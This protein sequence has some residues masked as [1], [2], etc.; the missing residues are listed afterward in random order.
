M[1]CQ[2]ESLKG[3]SGVDS[4]S[5]QFLDVSRHREIRRLPRRKRGS[6]DSIVAILPAW[7]VQC[8]RQKARAR[9]WP[10]HFS[11]QL[12]A[13]I[14]IGNRQGDRQR[15]ALA[16][17]DLDL[18]A[19]QHSTRRG[20]GVA[21]LAGIRTTLVEAE[22]NNLQLDA[23]SV[24]LPSLGLGSGSAEMMIPGVT[25]GGAPMPVCIGYFAWLAITRQCR[26]RLPV[27]GGGRL[28]I[29]RNFGNRR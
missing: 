22:V 19:V 16:G 28:A 5:T 2:L 1:N 24:Q 17:N 15:L 3:K 27:A 29:V 20:D 7:I 18:Q 11:G 4:S 9:A 26:D 14:Q 10:G 25:T 13:G 23:S 12:L 6:P 21:E 8:S